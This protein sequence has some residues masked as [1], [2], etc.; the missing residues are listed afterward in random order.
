MFS[1]SAYN[2][3]HGL[4][5]YVLCPLSLLGLPAPLAV[6]LP[7]PVAQIIGYSLLAVA[8]GIV[9]CNLYLSCRRCVVDGSASH[10]PLFGAFAASG[11]L[12]ALFG[13]AFWVPAL[14]VCGIIDVF[15]QI[16][17]ATVVIAVFRLDT[18]PGG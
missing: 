16:L 1:Q 10:F 5:G 9:L 14:L 17:L 3:V 13:L 11:G 2:I 15:G 6:F 8:A 18:P 12:A 7:R 4:I